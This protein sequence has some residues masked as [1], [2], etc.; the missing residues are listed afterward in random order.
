[1]KLHHVGRFQ[2]L[3]PSMCCCSYN[4]N[5]AVTVMLEFAQKFQYY[6]EP[7]LWLDRED[8]SL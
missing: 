6:L 7:L 5:T 4:W 2:Q 8:R 1:M 3:I